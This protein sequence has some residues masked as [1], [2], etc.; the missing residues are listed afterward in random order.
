MFELNNIK[1]FMSCPNQ[2]FFYSKMFKDVQDAMD[3]I[4]KIEKKKNRTML[5]RK[6]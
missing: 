1:I 2:F 4:L 6:K 3:D 5:K